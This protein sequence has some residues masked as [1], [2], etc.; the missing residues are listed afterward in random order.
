MSRTFPENSSLEVL[1]TRRIDQIVAKR[2]ADE[3]ERSTSN[4]TVQQDGV[5]PLVKEKDTI[6]ELHG[7][8]YGYKRA[9]EMPQMNT[10]DS[11]LGRS[12]G[13]QT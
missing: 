4:K 5:Y 10:N 6:L 12:L 2:E 3:N 13:N 1:N 7:L 11:G 8:E 9:I